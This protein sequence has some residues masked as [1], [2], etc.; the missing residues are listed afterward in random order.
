MVRIRHQLQKEMCSFE[1]LPSKTKS[2]RALA[3]AWSAQILWKQSWALVHLYLSES[4]TCPE[5][6]TPE[7]PLNGPSAKAWLYWTGWLQFRDPCPVVAT[8]GMLNGAEIV[9][10][11]YAKRR[12]SPKTSDFRFP[13][14]QN[15]EKRNYLI[16]QNSLFL[17]QLSVALHKCLDPLVIIDCCFSQMDLCCTVSWT[18]FTVG[19]GSNS[20]PTTE[21]NV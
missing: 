1:V 14:H 7:Q 21:G 15:M 2:Q 17:G 3:A 16:W 18:V 19:H 12:E 6:A 13:S 10:N 8:S 9:L 4:A 11:T 5:S 20:S